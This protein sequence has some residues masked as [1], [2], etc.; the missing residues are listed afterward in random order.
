MIVPAIIPETKKDLFKKI[1]YVKDSVDVVHIDICDGKYVP[2]VNWPIKFEWNDVE[3]LETGDEELPGW[4]KL[5]FEVDLM[6]AKPLEAL[7][8]FVKIGISS[9]II[10]A[11]NLKESFDEILK[12]AHEFDVMLGLAFLPSTNIQEYK[13]WIFKVDFVQCMGISKIGYQ[14]QD[15]DERVF[16]QIEKVKDIRPD[17]EIVVDG[18]VDEDN[19]QDLASLGV[20]KFV[21]GSTIWNATSIPQKISELKQLVKEV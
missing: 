9:A 12:T 10:H 11:E 8:H 15:F 13:D 14:G 21:I 7:D 6:T 19:I 1:N 3:G 2:S 18:H 17:I 4:D 16:D 5:D 20:S